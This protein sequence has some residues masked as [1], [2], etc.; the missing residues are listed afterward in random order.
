MSDRGNGEEP[1]DRDEDD[2]PPPP[3]RFY[4][5]ESDSAWERYLAMQE[6]EQ[7][8][9]IERDRA[10]IEHISEA[11]EAV[12]DAIGDAADAVGEA[13]E[14]AWDWMF[15]DDEEDDEDENAHESG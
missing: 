1:D 15:G 11:A 13:L 7:Q 3:N 9:A 10:I 8:L 2:G 5:P 6:R 12:G 4:D 14:S